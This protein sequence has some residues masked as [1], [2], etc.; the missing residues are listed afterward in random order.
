MTDPTNQ[1]SGPTSAKY[2][3]L[4]GLVF[5]LIVVSLGVSQNQEDW[6]GFGLLESSGRRKVA[7]DKRRVAGGRIAEVGGK[8]TVTGRR[9]LRAQGGL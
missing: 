3:Q 5:I 8:K 7:E 6:A 1:S 2:Q 4:P 9:R